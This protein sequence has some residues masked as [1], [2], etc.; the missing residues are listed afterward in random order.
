MRLSALLPLA[1]I[2]YIPTTS[3]LP[4]GIAV[5]S[6]LSAA[7]PQ[8]EIAPR[9]NHL[10]A[11]GLGSSSAPVPKRPPPPPSPKQIITTPKMN[12]IPGEGVFKGYKVDPETKFPITAW[13]AAESYFT[14]TTKGTIVRHPLEDELKRRKSWKDPVTGRT[15]GAIAVMGKDG[16]QYYH[17]RYIDSPTSL[18]VSNTEWEGRR[19]VHGYPFYHV[20]NKEF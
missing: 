10:E 7:V 20:G 19:T 15:N 11:R 6:Q 9:F 12:A 5:G 16:E 18:A 4:L 17:P 8:A 2:M 14:Q 1:L 3:A 13:N